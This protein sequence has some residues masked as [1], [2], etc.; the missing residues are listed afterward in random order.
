MAEI[1]SANIAY[2]KKDNKVKFKFRVDMEY[3]SRE[4][5]TH[6]FISG[7]VMEQD[8]F[9]DDFVV[10]ID[11][12]PFVPNRRDFSIEFIETASESAVDTEWGN[13]TVYAILKLL[14]L[15]SP[16][17]FVSDSITTNSIS[18]DV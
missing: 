12:S 16:R 15:E 17:P 2:S 4:L 7:K 1:R 18:V 10:S 6:W 13:E 3:E 5:N 14:P 8:R 11:S 9:W